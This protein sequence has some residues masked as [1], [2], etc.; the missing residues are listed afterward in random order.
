M[1][2]LGELLYREISLNTNNN[3]CSPANLP[4]RATFTPG[5]DG[6]GL[7]PAHYEHEIFIIAAFSFVA[8]FFPVN[9]AGLGADLFLVKPKQRLRNQKNTALGGWIFAPGA[10]IIAHIIQ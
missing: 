6:P 4:V 2:S 5:L 3:R 10:K 7:Y 1:Q 9:R 8:L